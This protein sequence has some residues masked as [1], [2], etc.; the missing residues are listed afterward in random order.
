MRKRRLNAVSRS[1]ARPAHDGSREECWVFDHNHRR[2]AF[3]L[4]ELLVVIAIIGVLVGLLLPAVQSAREAA[5]RARC[6]NNLKQV[7]LAMQLYHDSHQYLPYG[8]SDLGPYQQNVIGHSFWPRIWPF[9]EEQSTYSRYDMN[10]N[11]VSTENHQLMNKVPFPFMYCSSSPVPEFQTWG[12]SFLLANSTYVGI[13]G[14][15]DHPSVQPLDHLGAVGDGSKGG[16]LVSKEAIRLAQATDGASKTMC[17]AEQSDYCRSPTKGD[18]DCRSDCGHG[19]NVGAR[20]F[21]WDQRTFNLTTVRH[22]INEK[23]PNALGV[24]ENCGVNHAIQSAHPGG[25]HAVFADGAV[26]F[27]TD[28]TALP[29]LYQFANRDDEHVSGSRE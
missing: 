29:V 12:D 23:S 20:D 2:N 16:L 26:H 22:P 6:L 15:V 4:V 14:A 21:G 17:V 24:L 25:A 3:T 11:W 10:A 7:G 1:L 19:F 9:I 8:I 27:L 13:S 5:R 28:G 18:V